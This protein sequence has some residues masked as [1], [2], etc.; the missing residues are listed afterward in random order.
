MPAKPAKILVV[1]DEDQV[2]SVIVR[3]LEKR[4]YAVV[5]ADNGRQALELATATIAEYALVIS[6]LIMPVMGGVAL[7]RE[8]K[9]LRPDLP[10]LCM[11]GYSRDE[12]CAEDAL[13]GAHLIEKPFTPASF[14]TQIDEILA[15]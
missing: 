9:G 3:L 7:L 8:L 2:R 14:L 12:V 13:A 6:D 10:F 1:E 15:R 4:G 11:T 5:Q